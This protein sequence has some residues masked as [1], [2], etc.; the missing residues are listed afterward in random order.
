MVN[1]SHI[2][3]APR[4]DAIRRPSNRAMMV[5]QLS[6]S[7]AETS[8][9]SIL[10]SGAGLDLVNIGL[11]RALIDRGKVLVDLRFLR[12]PCGHSTELF[13]KAVDSLM[14]HVGLRDELRHGN[15]DVG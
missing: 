5:V 11:S 13:A 12:E 14:I 1:N 6:C 2:A 4:D 3:K 9:G 10:S 15:W 7:K 8:I